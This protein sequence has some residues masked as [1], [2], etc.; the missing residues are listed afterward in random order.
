[1]ETKG[2]A[3]MRNK[4]LKLLREKAPEPVSGEEL[5]KKLG[6]SRTAIWKHIQVLKEEGYGI[7][8]FTKKGYVLTSVPDKLLPSEIGE[9]L[10]TRFLGRH[11]CY[12]ESVVSSNEVL[13]KLAEQGAA[14]GTVCVA[15]EQTGGKGRLRRGWFSPKGKGLWF[16]VLLKPTFLPQ[17]APKMTLLAAVAVVRAIREV[18]G[19]EAQIKWPNDVL[20]DGKKLVGILTEM[21]AE[22]G[23]IN[24]LVCGTGINVCVPKE[25]VP[26][27]LRAS[28]VSIA[29]VTGGKVDR[30]ALLAKVLDYM[31]L[32]YDE[33]CKNGFGAI[34][35]Q[36]R[37]YSITLGKQ[38]KVI[39]P[40]K[41]YVGTAM[42]IDDTGA[43]QVR[44]EDGTVET[45][46]A[47]DVSIRPAQG[48]GKYA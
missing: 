8:A 21:S 34:F 25:M 10:H 27:D 41:T 38:V 43:L 14:D 3:A 18:C 2:S 7:E 37:K 20:L 22:F 11:I 16:S 46:L 36:W 42:D 5:A 32:Y 1:M 26:E 12:E 13:K 24:Y 31:E 30:V 48:K 19:V 29:D 4:I 15:E 33:A 40:D 47:G 23:H 28:A 17:E 9:K 6:I 35:D 45:V 44:K 39:A